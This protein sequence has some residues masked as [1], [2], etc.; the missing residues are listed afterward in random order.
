VPPTRLPS[1][2]SGNAEFDASR[3]LKHVRALA[4]TIG[5][6]VTGSEN[7][8]RAGDYIAQQFASYGYVIEKQAFAFEQWD[9]RATRIQITAPEARALDA[10]ALRFSPAGNADAPVVAV[11]G[12]AESDFAR[13]NVKDKIAL[14]P[15]GVTLFSDIA[16][17]AERAGAAATIIFNNAPGRF[18]GS[19]RDKTAR[20]VLAI[21]GRDGQMLLDWLGKGAVTLKLESDT[22]LAQKTGRN[23]I[24]TKRG[25][26][27]QIVVLGAHYDSVEETAGANDNASGVAVLLELAQTLSRKAIK[28]TLVFIAFDAEEVGLVGSR[29]YVT[30]LPDDARKQ[31]IAMLNFDMLGGGAGPLQLDGEGQVAK[32]ALEAAQELGIPARSFNLGAGYG[33]DH[34]SFRGAGIDAVFFMRNYDL[35]H[36]PQDTLD[37]VRAEWLSEAGR[38]AARVVELMDK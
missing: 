29:H 15:R 8:T 7:A 13:V 26:S 30:G 28:P 21:S 12:G 38:V 36:T 19:L 11:S 33:S 23:I 37:Q 3:A 6:R 24:A 25:T 35:L 9:D 16:L 17:N 14:V 2:V 22:L 32:F 34:A 10:R 18:V 31:I 27:D 4:E 1:R 5:T 20:P